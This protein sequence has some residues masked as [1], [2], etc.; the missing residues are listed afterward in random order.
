MTERI[1]S[2]DNIN[3][4]LSMT[5]GALQNPE[6]RA[7]LISRLED[8]RK[9]IQTNGD[10]DAL[11]FMDALCHLAIKGPS[12]VPE[13]EPPDAYRKPWLALVAHLQSADLPP[14]QDMFTTIRKNTVLVMTDAPEHKQ[15]WAENI[16]DN[17]QRAEARE[18]AAMLALLGAVQALL[19]DGQP[20]TT[21]P[22]LEGEYATC[23]QD[24]LA[25]LGG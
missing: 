11:G 7:E 9:D 5:M 23:W 6:Q 1:L 24:I 20:P 18:D 14:E 12:A 15:A 19:R 21:P 17:I 22:P 25:G 13:V 2:D 3:T 10:A 16:A 8:V 4:L